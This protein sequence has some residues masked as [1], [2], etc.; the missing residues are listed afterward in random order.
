MTISAAEYDAEAQKLKKRNFLL[1]HRSIIEPLLM[2]EKNYY[3]YLEKHNMARGQPIMPYKLYE[4]PKSVTNGTMKK[5]QLEGLSFLL[6]AHN[7]GVNVI[8]GTHT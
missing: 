8:L 4:Q 3:T 2:K 6:N 1:E 5:Y 7:N